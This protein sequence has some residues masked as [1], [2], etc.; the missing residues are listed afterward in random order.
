MTN[1]RYYAGIGSRTT[2]L[3]IQDQMTIFARARALEGWV[4]RSGGAAGADAAFE[5]GAMQAGGSSA[6]EIFKTKDVTQE[7]IRLASTILTSD[8]WANCN[9]LDR[10][11]H[12]R[13]CMQILGKDLSTPVLMVVA[14]TPN[15]E[16]IGGTRTGLVLAGLR[17]IKI[18]NLGKAEGYE[19]FLEWMK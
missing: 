12:G 19:D 4:L 9:D 7:A 16:L 3:P 13:N 14:W 2:P 5:L 11:Y 17:D 18:I 1:I 10:K 8:H 15:G 6:K